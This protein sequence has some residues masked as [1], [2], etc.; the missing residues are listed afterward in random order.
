MYLNFVVVI[1]FAHLGEEF[2]ITFNLF[3]QTHRLKGAL[4]PAAVSSD[5]EPLT[6]REAN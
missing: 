6:V 3:V 4:I 5:E 2:K 1:V